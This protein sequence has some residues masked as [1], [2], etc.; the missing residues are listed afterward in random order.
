MFACTV[1]ALECNIVLS[2]HELTNI[3]LFHLYQKSQA[4]Y[5]QHENEGMGNSSYKPNFDL[6]KKN[7]IH[8]HS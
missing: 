2:A 8:H 3:F 6:G 4:A 1:N 5:N 7:K